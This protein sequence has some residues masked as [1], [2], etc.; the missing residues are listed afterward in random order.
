MYLVASISCFR[1]SLTHHWYLNKLNRIV[2]M[3]LYSLKKKNRNEESKQIQKE[4]NEF[5]WTFSIRTTEY[6]NEAIVSLWFFSFQSLPLKRVFQRNSSRIIQR[7]VFMNSLASLKKNFVDI[8]SLFFYVFI[9]DDND[10]DNQFNVCGSFNRFF[11]YFH[12]IRLK[13][14]R[15]TTAHKSLT[16]QF[17]CRVCY[18]INEF[19]LTYDFG[20]VIII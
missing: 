3:T 2:W 16:Q 12:Q 7:T 19:R 9:H 1:M 17:I 13:S 15:L 14:F 4:T 11:S 6:L 18:K 10:D 5:D 20:F 8:I